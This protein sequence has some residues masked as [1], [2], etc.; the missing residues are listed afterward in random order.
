MLNWNG[1]EVGEGE[2]E[3]SAT[4]GVEWREEREQQVGKREQV[5]FKRCKRGKSPREERRI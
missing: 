4:E 2:M 1:K 3:K 5:A